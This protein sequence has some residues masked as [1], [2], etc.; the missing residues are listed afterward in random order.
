[1]RLRRSCV[2]PVVLGVIALTTAAWGNA[3][4]GSAKTKPKSKTGGTENVRQLDIRMQEMQE[5]IVKDA[6]DIAK[7]YEDAGQYDRAKVLLE[8]LEKLN[9]KLPGLKEKIEQLKEK[10]LDSTEF[11]IEMD[12][13]KG[14]TPAVGMVFKDRATRIEAEGDYNFVASGSITADGLPTSDNGTDLLGGVP[15]GALIGIVVNPDNK[16]PGKPFEI[17]AKR[18]WTP[19]ETGYLQLKVNV[20][21]GHKSTG[22]LTIKLGG[23]AK[24][25]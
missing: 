15:V 7:G 20:P 19:R 3:Q 11:E 17:K 12:V 13:A 21:N 18:E 1:M 14:W 22:K 4:T 23:V 25:N 8:V 16:K 2:I 9:P 6:A 10:G 24:V 5:R